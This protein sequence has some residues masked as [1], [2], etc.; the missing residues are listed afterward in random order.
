MVK[1]DVPVARPTLFVAVPRLLNKMYD[2]IKLKFSS[3]TGCKGWLLRKAIAAK[4]DNL[5][6]TGAVTHPCYDFIIFNKVKQ[7]LGGRVRLMATGSAPIA[8]E[9]MDMMK[10][11]FS[12]PVI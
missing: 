1:D 3:A 9:V 8:Q 2:S 7:V 5:K 12:C 10:I 4:L 11:C 6:K